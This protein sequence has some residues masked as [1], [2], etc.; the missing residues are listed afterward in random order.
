MFRRAKHAIIDLGA[1]RLVVQPG[2]TGGLLIHRRRPTGEAA[3]YAVLTVRLDDGRYL[4]YRDIRRLG[5]LLLLDDR[6][7]R[8]YDEA[9]GPEP[10]DPPSPRR[11]FRER[12][13]RSAGRRSRRS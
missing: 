6:G 12:L 10:L 9:L 5:T 1:R 2:M 8:P 4:V 13:G 7:W 11:R 3:R